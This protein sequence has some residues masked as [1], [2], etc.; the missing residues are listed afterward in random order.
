[1]VQRKF[2]FVKVTL[3]P[4]DYEKIKEVYRLHKEQKYKLFDLSSWVKTDDDLINMIKD[5]IEYDEV[6]LAIDTENGRYAGCITFHDMR[7]LDDVIIDA[8]VHPV[9]SKRYWGKLSRQLI[10]D[11]YKF[12]ED[13]WLPINRLTARVPAHNFGVI[14]LL[15]DLGFKIEGTLKDYYVFKDKNGNNK[16]YN[17][18]IYSDINRRK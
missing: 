14:K 15:K 1:M 11:A 13:N 16:Y 9:I 7:I 18:L 6:L 12:V 4:D 8:E 3:E 10:E 2:D 17:Q 5:R